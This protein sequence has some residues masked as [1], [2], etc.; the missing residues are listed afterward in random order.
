M[1]ALATA[2]IMGAAALCGCAGNDFPSEVKPDWDDRTNVE[3]TGGTG[4]GGSYIRN[5]SLSAR[6]LHINN[7]YSGWVRYVYTGTSSDLQGTMDSLLVTL[8]KLRYSKRQYERGYRLFY[9]NEGDVEEIDGTRY[10]TIRF[11]NLTWCHESYYKVQTLADY[12]TSTGT[13]D[14]NYHFKDFEN[15]DKDYDVVNAS[16]GDKQKLKVW[17]LQNLAD[18]VVITIEGAFRY[19]YDDGNKTIEQKDGGIVFET[20]SKAYFIYTDK[21]PIDLTLLIVGIVAGLAVIGAGVAVAVVLHRKK[22]A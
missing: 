15:P 1:L 11:V 10:V 8:N 20:D 22:S 4:S 5:A 6:E 9:M 18:G 16:D 13:A 7:D 17:Q 12:L 21:H 2:L 19:F 3:V 14:M